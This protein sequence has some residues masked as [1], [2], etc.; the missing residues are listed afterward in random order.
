MSRRVLCT[1]KDLQKRITSL[2]GQ[3]SDGKK[4]VYSKSEA[5][6][7]IVKDASAF[8][9]EEESPPVYVY[10]TSDGHLKTKADATSKNNLDNLPNC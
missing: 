3:K 7:M 2:G 10:V 5:K 4:W 1:G 9:V 8:Y 6:A